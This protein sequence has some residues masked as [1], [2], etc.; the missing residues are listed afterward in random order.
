MAR[1][2]RRGS[3][4]RSHRKSRMGFLTGKSAIMDA[5]GLVA[6]SAVARV[7]TNSEKILPNISPTIKSAGVVAIG[8][9]FPKLMKGELGQSIGAGM[10]AGGGLGLLQ[11]TN[12]LSGIGVTDTMS[13]PVEVMAGDDVSVMAGYSGD[14]LSVIAGMEEEY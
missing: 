12:I 4:K 8:M 7:L 14:N 6:G 9:F 10:I 13:I 2:K 3:Y 11:S 1:R 5:V